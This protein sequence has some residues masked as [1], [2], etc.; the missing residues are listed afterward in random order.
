MS[1][2][3]FKEGATVVAM[4][5]T[6]F[7]LTAGPAVSDAQAGHAFTAHAASAAAVP[8]VAPND[9]P[10]GRIWTRTAKSSW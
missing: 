8:G 9:A 1:A 2:F 4:A 6:S 7:M 10:V 5:A 3:L